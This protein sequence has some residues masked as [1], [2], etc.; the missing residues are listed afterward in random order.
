[1]NLIYKDINTVD[2]PNSEINIEIE[3]EQVKNQYHEF[4]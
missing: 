1:M 4:I 2:F 3:M